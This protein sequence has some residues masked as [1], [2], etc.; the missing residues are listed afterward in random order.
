MGDN[1]YPKWIF[2]VLVG[3]REAVVFHSEEGLGAPGHEG[4]DGRK[5]ASGM[6]QHARTLVSAHRVEARMNIAEMI[7]HK[8]PEWQRFFRP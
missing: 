6:V 3:A 2:S 5:A 7:A 4:S 8:R 1:T